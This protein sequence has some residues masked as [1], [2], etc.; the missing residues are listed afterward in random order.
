MAIR[1][2]S[3][4]LDVGGP[5]I[6]VP[7]LNTLTTIYRTSQN[8]ER[9]ETNTNLYKVRTMSKDNKLY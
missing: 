8:Y 1:R 2:G 9:G 5:R 7:L 6:N 3:V 4:A